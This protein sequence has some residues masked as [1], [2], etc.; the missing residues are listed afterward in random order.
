MHPTATDVLAHVEHVA[1]VAGEDHVGIG[2]DNGV[3]PLNM[4]PENRKR[5]DDWQRQRIKLGIAAPGE[6]V[7][8]YPYVADYNSVDCLPLL[9]PTC[10]S[11][12][13]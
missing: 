7:G 1:N 2:T 6:A 9:P 8:F 3:L 13:G 11:G 4:D 12:A 5:M 10:K